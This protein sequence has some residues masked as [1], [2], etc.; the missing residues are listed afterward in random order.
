MS[1]KTKVNILKKALPDYMNNGENT[2][3][4]SVTHQQV[5]KVLWNKSGMNIVV[6]YVLKWIYM[7]SEALTSSKNSTLYRSL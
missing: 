1:S 2:E 6:N 7:I 5:A 4:S 3:Y